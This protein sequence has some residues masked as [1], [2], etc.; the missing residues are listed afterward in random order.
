MQW[1]I[2]FSLIFPTFKHFTPNIISVVVKSTWTWKLILNHGWFPPFFS[3]SPSRQCP[4]ASNTACPTPP[5]RRQSPMRDFTPWRAMTTS[6]STAVPNAKA[7][8]KW[9]KWLAAEVWRGWIF[10]RLAHL[11]QSCSCYKGNWLFW[12][13][14]CHDGPEEVTWHHEHWVKSVVTLCG[15][16]GDYVVWNHRWWQH[17]LESVV[18]AIVKTQWWQHCLEQGWQCCV[19]VVVTTLSKVSGD[20]TL[21]AIS[22]DN[23]VWNQLTMFC[24]IRGNNII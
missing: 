1:F 21:S 9:H 12:K 6:R 16:D 17:C 23:I 11:N 8:S 20:I 15:I 13:G 14:D 10:F 18:A 3:N 4:L 19:E 22:G 24:R 7:R 2:F 5:W